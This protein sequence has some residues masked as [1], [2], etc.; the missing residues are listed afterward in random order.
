MRE[1]TCK[2]LII[3]GGP[4][5]Y[6]CG[7]RAGQLGIDT[8]LVVEAALGGTCLT[9]GCIPSKAMIHVA[10]EY[11]RMSRLCTAPMA[12]LR[13]KGVELDLAETIAWKDGIVQQLCH[14]VEGL[15]RKAGVTHIRGRATL[16]DGKTAEVETSDGPLSIR[17]E[18]QVLATGS[19]PVELPFLP[20][21]GDV[22]SSATALAIT[23]RPE[24]LA[25]VGGGYIG[26]ELGMA[27][28]KIGS[29][30]TILEAGARILPAWDAELTAPV[31]Q[32]LD[33]LDVT[34]LTETRAKG[35]I[36][37]RLSVERAG[38]LE[39]IAAD[40]VLVTVGRKPR[41]EG[42]GIAALDLERAGPFLKID[43]QC[44]TSMTGVYAIGDVT[45]EPMLA[46]RAMAQG[47]LVA[48]LV[49]GQRKTWDHRAMPT[50]CFTDPEIVS[51][52]R[53][54]DQAPDGAKVTSFPF[55]ANGKALS[56]HRSEGFVRILADP[57]G[58]EILGIQAVGPGV[59]EFAGEF[60][61]AIEMGATLAD[62]AATI[63]AHPTKGE[64]FH[65]A[66]LRTMGR[67]L[68]L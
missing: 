18:T 8:V 15:L 54:P 41:S 24:S 14:G 20:F 4:G 28:A 44:R 13:S 62:V 21:G 36:A 66:V 56:E 58:R 17:C 11:H 22:L 32:A 38:T 57:A 26:L 10:D 49:A 19:D 37:G 42:A 25:I 1:I 12:G 6:V 48:E 61:L 27:F 47:E 40:K 3:G 67:A 35:H 30:V 59:S 34:V 5:G 23:A 33:R 16:R 53:L 45:G 50:V 63:H 52:G 55:A 68:H 31:R 64:V 7:I 51:V 43:A 39:E 60:A 29:R 46:H 2:L 9:V 65:E